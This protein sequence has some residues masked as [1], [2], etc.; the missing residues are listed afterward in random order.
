MAGA[1]SMSSEIVG[2]CQL[3]LKTATEDCNCQLQLLT[4]D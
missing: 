2:D 4:E 1:I 3:Q